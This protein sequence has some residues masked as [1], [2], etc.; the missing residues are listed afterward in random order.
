MLKQDVQADMQCLEYYQQLSSELVA[1]EIPSMSQ[2]E[3]LLDN[4]DTDHKQSD[5]S[6]IIQDSTAIVKT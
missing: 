2:S 6:A 4:V 5:F 3:E 1:H